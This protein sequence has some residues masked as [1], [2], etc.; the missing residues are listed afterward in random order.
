MMED[1]T[2]ELSDGLARWPRD[3]VPEDG[4]SISRW[5]ADLLAGMRRREDQYETAMKLT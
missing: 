5:I 1:V 2:V 4:C 3:R